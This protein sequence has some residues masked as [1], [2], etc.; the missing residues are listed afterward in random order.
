MSVIECNGA[1]WIMTTPKRLKANDA[2]DADRNK[3]EPPLAIRI[4]EPVVALDC[5][6][7]RKTKIS[8][9]VKIGVAG[10]DAWV[11]RSLRRLG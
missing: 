8:E 4:D 6:N 2:R 1:S 9:E 10:C 7:A 11:C 5:R 3:L